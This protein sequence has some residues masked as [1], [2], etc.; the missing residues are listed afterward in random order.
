MLDSEPTNHETDTEEATGRNAVTAP[1]PTVF[2]GPA[3]PAVPPG[4]AALFQPPQ[5]VF[6][7]P[8]ALFPPRRALFQPPAPPPPSADRGSADRQ[9]DDRD[10]DDRDSDDR[11]SAG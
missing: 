2:N 10:S 5:G 3:E 8:A 4:P 9:P 6:Q 11:D 7:L 1:A